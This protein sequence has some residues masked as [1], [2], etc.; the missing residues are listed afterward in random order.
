[1]VSILKYTLMELPGGASEYEYY[2]STSAT[3]RLVKI[4][5]SPFIV[6]YLFVRHTYYCTV[7]SE[8][9][10]SRWC[11]VDSPTLGMMEHHVI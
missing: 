9:H 3:A 8:A 4:V 2:F 5:V 6:Q 10:P 11:G 7:Y 1:M